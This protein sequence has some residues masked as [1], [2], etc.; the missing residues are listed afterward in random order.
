MILLSDIS[1]YYLVV[2]LATT[3]SKEDILEQ[4]ISGIKHVEGENKKIDMGI[5]N[6]SDAKI[7][8]LIETL[9]F[10]L[11]YINEPVNVPNDT[12]FD[13]FV[14]NG[15]REDDP[16]AMSEAR[17]HLERQLTKFECHFDERFYKL[18]D[19]H[20]S[21]GLLNAHDSRFTLTGS[22]DLVI[23]P[24]WTVETAARMELCVAFELKTDVA[25]RN[26]GIKA[27]YNQATAELIAARHSSHQPGVLVVLSDLCNNTSIFEFRYRNGKF[28]IAICERI[29]LEQMAVKVSQFMRDNNVPDAEFRPADDISRA[30][31]RDHG[32]IEFKRQKVMHQS[33]LALE[34]FQDMAMDPNEWTS[35]ERVQ[36]LG[37]LFYS[38]EQPMH[39]DVYNMMYT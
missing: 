9:D 24:Y 31:E 22:T 28:S 37:N 36:I 35:K 34:Q 15:R 17:D 25:M 18:C 4:V 13:K 8:K 23:I 27:F 33:S 7:I 19:V 20:S 39:K 16:T 38:M 32:V 30:P 2:F 6:V 3:I 12:V 10:S 14:W 21:H 26:K 11:T 1:L 29:T 5:S